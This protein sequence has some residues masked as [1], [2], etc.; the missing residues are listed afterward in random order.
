MV[1]GRTLA[2]IPAYNEEA[3]LKKVITSLRKYHNNVDILVVNDGSTDQTSA[4]AR[5][6]GVEVIDLPVNL[7][8]GGAVQTGYIY[9]FRKGY[10]YAVQI[11]GD[12]QHDPCDLA[13]VLGPVQRG[14]CDLVIGSRFVADTG[15]RQTI[16]RLLGTKILSLIVSVLGQKKIKDPTSGYRAANRRAIKVFAEEYP[17]DY[18]EAESLILL[19][20][21]GLRVLE[22]PVT[23]SNRATGQSSIT[24]WR[25][26][27]YMLKVPLAILMVFSRSRKS[28][29][30]SSGESNT[31]SDKY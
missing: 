31:V 1:S 7:G 13:T 17:V 4:A 27:Y 15:Y 21:K 29:D 18:P 10:D 16:P 25:S 8:I 12:G 23:M 3:N 11:D 9:A 22:V 5:T 6:M 20:R 26:A 24:L 19:R 14:E 30:V 28:G 2:I